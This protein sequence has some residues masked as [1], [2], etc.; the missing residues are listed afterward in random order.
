MSEPYDQNGFPSQKLNEVVPEM[1]MSEVP[2][3]E[4]AILST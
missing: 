3:P 1:G 4:D 2:S